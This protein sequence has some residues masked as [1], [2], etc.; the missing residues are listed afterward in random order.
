M[1][2]NASQLLVTA[3]ANRHQI[4][5]G[6]A[7][8]V[9]LLKLI[10]L[11]CPAPNKCFT[12]SYRLQSHKSSAEVIDIPL[13]QHFFCPQCY[14]PIPC[15]E[16]VSCCPNSACQI[17]LHPSVL[18][19]IEL[20]ILAQLQQL[21]ASQY[22][23]DVHAE[24]DSQAFKSIT[25]KISDSI[26]LVSSRCALAIPVV[27]LQDLASANTYRS[28]TTNKNSTLPTW[29]IYTM[30]NSIRHSSRVAYWVAF[31]QS[32]SPSTQMVLQCFSH[33]A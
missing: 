17:V 1:S 24:C 30:G 19:F 6:S 27:L 8:A 3:Y 33:R 9:D 12:S 11:Y 31:T 26:Q 28:A 22:L 20:P 4:P 23:I 13:V 10:A 2:V 14:I 7:E 18:S 25:L 21:C 29:R 5:Q 16:A 15:P 32:P